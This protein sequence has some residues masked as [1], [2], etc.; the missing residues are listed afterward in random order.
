M[1]NHEVEELERLDR[2]LLCHILA[3]PQT[4]PSEALFLETG[5]LNIGTIVKMRRVNYL[6]YL[7]KCDENQLL[8]KF[9]KTQLLFPVK[10]DWSEQVRQDLEDFGIKEDFEW[11]KKTSQYKFRK[12][13][14]KCG[15]EYAL[16]KFCEQKRRHSKL[17]QLEYDDLKIQGYLKNKDVSVNQAQILT[18]FRT[19]MAK[20]ENNYKGTS[21][22]Q[23]C[24]LCQN[25]S[26]DQQEI[27]QCDFNLKNLNLRG[28][29]EDLFKS[30]V[31]V[32]IIKS[33]EALYKLR[34]KKLS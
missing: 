14:K 11:I 34:E 32:S 33:L 22:N 10:D 29:Y 6:Q 31:D 23:N 18:K 16:A 25:H 24:K 15:R 30:D 19:R 28:K 7:L 13:I 21:T 20:Y 9:F 27:Y 5:S 17:D 3:L 4:T 1:R 2:M 8:S 26:D 12:L